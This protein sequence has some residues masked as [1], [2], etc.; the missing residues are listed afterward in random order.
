MKNIIKKERKK[1][2]LSQTAL[3]NKLNVSRQTIYSLETKKFCPSAVI[4]MKLAKIFSL[5]TEDVF[6]LETSDYS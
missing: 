5:K 1:L 2:K 3:A 4:A 6:Q